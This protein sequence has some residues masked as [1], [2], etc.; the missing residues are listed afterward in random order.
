LE[1]DQQIEIKN[2]IF[3][4]GIE[5][6]HTV[7]ALGYS[8]IERR[9]KLKEE[10]HNLPQEKLR[11]LKNSGQE[12]TRTL[13][14]PL[15]SYSGDTEM[16]PA[17]F[18]DEFAN[19]R[20]VI[21]ECT[22]FEDDHRSRAAVGKHLHIQDI[23]TLLKVWRAEAVVIIHVSRRTNLSESREQLMRLAGPNDASRV[24]FLMDL[25]GNRMRHERQ[26]RDA[27]EQP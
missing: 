19:S 4:R 16:G 11:E 13:E 18:R 2:N 23:A 12:I 26:L 9:S 25:R 5:M 3:L 22:F 17:L 21:C 24:H 7:P 15:V 20:I 6:I 8:V 27:G 10:F 1:P 14:I